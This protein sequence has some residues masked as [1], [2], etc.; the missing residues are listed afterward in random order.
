MGASGWVDGAE[1][2][3]DMS[4]V[5]ASV[6]RT[7]PDRGVAIDRTFLSFAL[8]SVGGRPE[9]LRLGVPSVLRQLHDW[10]LTLPKLAVL[11]ARTVVVPVAR[12]A[13]VRPV[14]PVVAV[15]PGLGRVEVVQ[16]G[17]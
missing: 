14:V 11:E 10:G 16:H 9:G 6:S 5:R 3:S 13:A 15:G 12:V 4:M 7:S 2:G 1:T 17:A 8:W